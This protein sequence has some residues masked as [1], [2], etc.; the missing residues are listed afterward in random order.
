MLQ[1]NSVAIIYLAMPR[2]SLGRGIGIQGAAQAMGLA[3]GPAV[4]GLLLAAGGWRLIFLINVP[5]GL[6]GMVAAWLF[7]PRSRNLQPRVPFDWL[8]SRAVRARRAGAARRPCR[9]GIRAGW[10]SP[11][12]IGLFAAAV[13]LGV[14][15]PPGKRAH[16]ADG[17][18]VAVPADPVRG[19]D[20]QRPA[21]IPGHVRCVVRRTVLPGALPA[22]ERKPGRAAADGHA[23]WRSA[24]TAPFAGQVRRPIRARPLTVGGMA[25]VAAVWPRWPSRGV[26]PGP[27]V[28][29]LALIGIGLGL[30]TPPN[31]AAIMASAPRQSGLA[32]GILNMTRGRDGARARPHRRGLR[33]RR[34]TVA[35]IPD[36][37]PVPGHRGSRG[38]L[39]RFPPRARTSRTRRSASRPRPVTGHGAGRGPSR[40]VQPAGLHPATCRFRR[41]FPLD[42]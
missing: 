21:L 31:N 12:I 14:A 1:A 17:G 11:A 7:I 39:A 20:R 42:R 38:R 13:A 27:L 36:R 18:P 29:E 10:T 3:L 41:A 32:G 4:G 25:L 40:P 30:F 28:G 34:L 19:W 23:V 22:S 9:S 33:T 6:V 8:G 35:G 5:I 26:G 24:V 2:G 16:L 15:S 37:G